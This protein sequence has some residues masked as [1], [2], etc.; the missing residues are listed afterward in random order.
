MFEN[1]KRANSIGFWDDSKT[2][3]EKSTIHSNQIEGATG[4]DDILDVA[5]FINI[6]VFCAYNPLE[7]VSF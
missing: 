6:L 4:T 5:T 2:R 3:F 7:A 1:Q